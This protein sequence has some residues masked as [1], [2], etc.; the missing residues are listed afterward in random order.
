MEKRFKTVCILFLAFFI[1]SPKLILAVENNQNEQK[2]I[3][4]SIS[5][6]P[7][8]FHLTNVK[9]GDEM[10]RE[11]TIHNKGKQDFSYLFS[12]QFLKGSE[13]FYNELFIEVSDKKNILVKG[14]LKDFKE[15]DARELESN[16]SEILYFKVEIPY[17]LGNEFQGLSTEFQFNFFVEGPMGA[18][19]PVDGNGVLPYTGTIY[20]KI[21][22]AGIALL[23]TG[24]SLY[25]YTKSKKN[26]MAASNFKL[27]ENHLRERNEV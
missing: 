27:A 16:S 23:I 3:D 10:S 13:K 19:L 7:I 14:K 15:L 6:S 20:Y 18:A 17:E 2:E 5:P 11:V 12:N 21:L 26:V 4:I 1:F 9:P 22:V 24:M 8:L 25:L